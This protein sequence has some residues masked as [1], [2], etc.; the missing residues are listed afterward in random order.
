MVIFTW[1]LNVHFPELYNKSTN[2]YINKKKI[3]KIDNLSD[4]NV[5]GEAVELS[6]QT[7]EWT[8]DKL[9]RISFGWIPKVTYSNID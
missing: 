3:R 4:T 7:I 9:N 5:I 2:R 1:K 6:K 8:A